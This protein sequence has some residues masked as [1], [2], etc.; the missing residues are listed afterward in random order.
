MKAISK[1]H[2]FHGSIRIKLHYK[3][4]T[5]AKKKVSS[6]I[7][8]VQLK[9]PVQ[10]AD[11]FTNDSANDSPTFFTHAVIEA[12]VVQTTVMWFALVMSEVTAGPWNDSRKTETASEKKKEKNAFF[13]S[14][15]CVINLSADRFMGALTRQAVEVMVTWFN[16]ICAHGRVATAHILAAPLVFADKDQ[17]TQNNK[18]ASCSYFSKKPVF[19]FSNK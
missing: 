5:V 16:V 2:G 11:S 7:C 15:F 14:G 4:N 13:C 3:C 10:R 1:H 6:C 17:Q 12:L 8:N 18:M 19:R 9:D